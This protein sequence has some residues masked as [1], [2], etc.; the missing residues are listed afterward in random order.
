MTLIANERQQSHKSGSLDRFG[1]GVLAGCRATGFAT[2]NDSTVTADQFLQKLNV[3]VIDI[4][5]AGSFAINKQGVLANGA[6]F[7]L[8]LAPHFRTAGFFQH[9]STSSFEVVHNPEGGVG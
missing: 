8:H 7:G 4:H 3:L 5:W 9:K 1:H 2:T 6:R